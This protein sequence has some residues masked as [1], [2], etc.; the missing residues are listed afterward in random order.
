MRYR[1]SSLTV[2]HVTSFANTATTTYSKKDQTT[3]RQKSTEAVSSSSSSS[4]CAFDEEGEAP[5]TDVVE[6]PS[7]RNKDSVEDVPVL[8]NAKEHA[9]GYLSRILNARVYEAA[10]ETELQEAK[11]LSTHL[12][13]A[14]YL[15]REDMQPVFS[16]KIRGAYNR[17]A[18]LSRAE[19]DT[20][21]VA[22]SAGNHA[23]GVAMAA[24]MLGCRAVIVMV[25]KYVIQ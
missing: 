25:S 7:K 18:H 20:G 3:T 8:L 11:N 12:K 15:K 9:V 2:R 6:F 24:R 19:L 14:V 4:S 5:S 22:C 16:F 1:G 17:M 13:N 23:Q 21:V 10:I